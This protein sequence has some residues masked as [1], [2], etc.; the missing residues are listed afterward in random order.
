MKTFITLNIYDLF[1]LLCICYAPINKLTSSFIYFWLCSAAYG[2]LVPPRTEPEPPA[3]EGEV[4]T[5]GPRG[6]SPNQ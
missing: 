6:N 2:I 3:V 4:L 1:T 5:N